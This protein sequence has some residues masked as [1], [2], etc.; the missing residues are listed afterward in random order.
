MITVIHQVIWLVQLQLDRK[1]FESEGDMEN[2][3]EKEDS[4]T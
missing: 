1:G 3:P 4:A 2:D